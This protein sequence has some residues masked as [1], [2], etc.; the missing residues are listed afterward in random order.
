MVLMFN[1]SQDSY[2]AL[3]DVVTE[4]TNPI[5]PVVGAGLS[6]PA[7]L[8]DWKGLRD[9]L[10]RA[11]ED[12]LSY[13]EASEQKKRDNQLRAA[14]ATGDL[15]QSFHILKKALGQTTFKSLIRRS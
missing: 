1:D 9:L 5:V 7:G 10:C 8:P 6:R 14:R 3:R 2:R 4:R 15:W 11:G 13:L 12:E